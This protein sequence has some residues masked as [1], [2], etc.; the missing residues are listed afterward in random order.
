MLVP[1]TKALLPMIDE[2]LLKETRF[3][4][5]GPC[6]VG[7]TGAVGEDEDMSVPVS[8]APPCDASSLHCFCPLRGRAEGPP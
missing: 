2:L 6:R 3:E 4:R 5:S 7:Q 8:R 1:S